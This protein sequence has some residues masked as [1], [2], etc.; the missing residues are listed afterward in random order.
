MDVIQSLFKAYLQDARVFAA[1]HVIVALFVLVSLV[2]F[3]RWKFDDEPTPTI[4]Q[5][6]EI[7][8]NFIH[9]LIGLFLIIGIAGTFLGLWD[10]AST[11]EPSSALPASGNQAETAQHASETVQLLLKGIAKAFPVGFVGLVFTLVANIFAGGIESYKRRK[12][13]AFMDV[14]GDPLTT[15]LVQALGPVANLGTTL[16]QGLKPVIDKLARTLEPIAIFMAD[17]QHELVNAKTALI[18]AAEALKSSGQQISESVTGLKEMAETAHA[19]LESAKNLSNGIR[20]YFASITSK[21][22]QATERATDAFANYDKSLGA[23]SDSVSEA[24]D[25]FLTFPAQLRGDVTAALV[26]SYNEASAAREDELKDLY[27]AAR[28]HFEENM[29][30]AVS[31]VVFDLEQAGTKLETLTSRMNNSTVNAENAI[32]HLEEAWKVQAEKLREDIAKQID[33]GFR[34]ELSTSSKSAIEALE[35]AARSGDVFAK[36]TKKTTADIDRLYREAGDRLTTAANH[37]GNRLAGMTR[38][39]ESAAAGLQAA[40][41]RRQSRPPGRLR[42]FGRS[43]WAELT[44][45]IRIFPRRKR[46]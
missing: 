25:A 4:W 33:P 29:R 15:K 19:A 27:A 18:E 22:D 10:V 13:E 31:D 14:V 2:N 20:T 9:G 6:F 16:E 21:L 26:S 42:R 40:A 17:Q 7:R 38:E 35:E 45:P 44:R 8:S 37:L 28:K 32:N 43:V 11:L 36:S 41:E 3:K 46:R 12:I 23:M 30:N 39:I 1:A 34:K 5:Q 24:A